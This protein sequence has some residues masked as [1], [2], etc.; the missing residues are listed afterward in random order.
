V[1]PKNLLLIPARVA[2]RIMAETGLT[3]R[4]EV[5]WERPTA[6]PESVT[7]RPTRSH[8]L[9]YL[10]TKT[11]PTTRK[12][13]YN[14]H[15]TKEPRKSAPANPGCPSKQGMVN[16]QRLLDYIRRWGDPSGKNA[17]TVW[18]IAPK[19]YRGPHPATFPVG[20]AERCL[21]ATLPPG[22]VVIDP[23]AGAGTTAIA[24]LRLGA[25]QVTLI[26]LNQSYLDEARMRIADVAA[27]PIPSPSSPMILNPSVTL[28]HGDCRDILPGLPSDSFDV[29]VA[30][31]PYWLR[32]PERESLVDFHRRNNGRKPRIRNS[33]DQ[34]YSADDYLDVTEGW[35]RHAI[36][37][38]HAKGSLFIFANQHNFGLVSYAL[39]RLGIEV[40]NHIVWHK[41]NAEPNY[42]GRRLACKHE[43]IIWAIKKQGYRF[44][45]K[46]VKAAEYKDKR[47]GVQAHDVWTIPLLHATEAVGHPAQKPLSVYQRLFDMAGVQGG[48]LLDPMCGSGTAAIAAMRW[49]MRAV[50]IEREKEYIDL[51]RKRVANDNFKSGV[52]PPKESNDNAKVPS[53]ATEV[54]GERHA[55]HPLRRPTKKK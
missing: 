46:A 13:F 53:G 14:F 37:L 38:L 8:E 29:V 5:V 49:G 9:I 26:D 25:S 34:F 50:V 3:L 11:K 51:I 52:T 7:D 27:S 2:L 23:F 19:P 21:R 32:L 28:Y 15:A 22:G 18:R 33:W 1:G 4:A 12:Y 42:S 10:F 45:Y 24:A 43:V 36:R 39:Q 55:K 41:P 35:L 48:A 17:R 40:I 30:D 54:A 20:L 31:P 47:A 6:R 16:G 44:N